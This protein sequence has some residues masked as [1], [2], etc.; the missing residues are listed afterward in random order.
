M[1][2]IR[3]THTN[4]MTNDWRRLP[5]IYVRVFACEPVSSERHNKGPAFDALTGL[6]GAR[7][8]GATFVFRD[9]VNWG[10][11]SKVFNSAKTIRG[12]PTSLLRPG[13]AH[14]AFEVQKER[15]DPALGRA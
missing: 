12:L 11:R 5:E 9:T 13:F 4:L 3:Y 8:R 7:S 14:L 2:E 15:A 1:Q 10:Q 6:I